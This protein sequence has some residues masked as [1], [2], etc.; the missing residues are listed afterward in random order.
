MRSGKLTTIIFIRDF[1]NKGQE[2]SGYID[3]A[4]RMRTE[5][6]IPIFEQRCVH[7]IA[8]TSTPLFTPCLINLFRPFCQQKKAFAEACGSEL[9]QLGDPAV[10][11]QLHASLPGEH[12]ICCVTL[13][14]ARNRLLTLSL[15]LLCPLLSLLALPTPGDRRQ[16]TGSAVQEQA[17]PQDRKRESGEQGARRQHHSSGAHYLGV[18]PSGA[19]RPLHQAEAV[20][21]LGLVLGFGEM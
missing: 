6:F 16:R 8:A 1:N 15:I 7:K 19:V 10:H 2:V 12:C 3:L 4:H 9:L 20:S 21:W 13:F 17:R 11:L 14:I 5:D 18:H